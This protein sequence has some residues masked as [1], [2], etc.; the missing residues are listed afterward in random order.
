M[1]VLTSILSRTHTNS[2]LHT[3]FI[4]DTTL[5]LT[6]TFLALVKILCFRS[7]LQNYRTEIDKFS[8]C[9]KIKSF[10]NLKVAAAAIQSIDTNH[11]YFKKKL[12][13][14][15]KTLHSPDTPIGYMKV[16]IKS[17]FLLQ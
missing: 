3:T 13:L 14:D 6:I 4:A 5:R 11:V 1:S 2:G 7:H 17:D 10:N 9:V 12:P 16:E 8:I 15:V